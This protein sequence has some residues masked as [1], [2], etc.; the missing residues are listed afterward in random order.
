M[1]ASFSP[2]TPS[3]LAGAALI[4][5]ST[6]LRSQMGMAVLL[7]DTPPAQLPRLFHHRA[8]R[9]LATAAALAEL[10][11]DKLPFTPPRT[12]AR[13]LVPRIGLG[14][15]TAGLLGRNAGAPTT[16]SAAV[17]AGTAVGAAFAGKAARGALATLLPPLAAGLVED[18]VAVVL[19]VMALRLA[20]TAASDEGAAEAENQLTH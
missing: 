8:A 15:L 12:R 4:G 16:A 1:E 3:A 9:P 17:G 13:G 19:T 18:L 6:G 11:V 20:P 5:A 7:N 14:G 2:P 10:M